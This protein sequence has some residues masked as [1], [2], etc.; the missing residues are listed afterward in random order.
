[1]KNSSKRRAWS[2][3]D[4]RTLKSLARKK[5]KIGK[6]T[7]ALKGTRKRRGKKPS[8]LGFHSTLAFSRYVGGSLRERHLIRKA[9][10]EPL[11]TSRTTSS[12]MSV[13]SRSAGRVGIAREPSR[14]DG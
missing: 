11:G 7:K 6:I 2:A 4:V 12:S 10:D 14:H 3:S 9:G 5:T 8:T 1:M 13:A